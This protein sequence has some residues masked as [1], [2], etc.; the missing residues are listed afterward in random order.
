MSSIIQNK[1]HDILGD[2]ARSTKFTFVLPVISGNPELMNHIAYSVKSLTLPTI[3]NTPIEFK[4]KGNTI[5]IRGQTKFSQS[6]TVTFYLS[7]TH[8]LKQFFEDWIAHLEQRHYY[9]NPRKHAQRQRILTNSGGDKT[10][11]MTW[12]NTTAYVE[13]WDFDG[14]KPTAL[15]QIFN[16]FPT[17]VDAPDYSYES[18]GQIAEFT[19][20]FACSHFELYSKGLRSGN[21]QNQLYHTTNRWDIMGQQAERSKNYNRYEGEYWWDEERFRTIGSFMSSEGVT[22]DQTKEKKGEVYWRPYELSRWDNHWN[23]WREVNEGANTNP[24]YDKKLKD[25]DWDEMEEKRPDISTL[26]QK[27]YKPVQGDFVYKGPT[28]SGA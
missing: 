19:V 25:F 12:Y 22:L 28:G 21:V 14:M 13:Q 24:A 8:I 7:E 20:T 26:L 9:Y 6:F 17:K 4:Y 11:Y 16:V 3:E 15:Y 2:A 5:P 18:V 27:N 10:P 1:F 23:R